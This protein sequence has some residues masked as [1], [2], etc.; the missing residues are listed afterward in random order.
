MKGRRIQITLHL[1]CTILEGI[2]D[3]AVAELINFD[4]S[5]SFDSVRHLYLSYGKPD[6]NLI[7]LVDQP[8]VSLR[9]CY[10]IGKEKATERLRCHGRFDIVSA[11]AL[12]SHFGV[13]APLSPVEAQGVI[14]GIALPGDDHVLI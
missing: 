2:N 6:S 9:Q 14:R 1:I 4:P 10:G 13:G 7:L 8:P 11:I 12:T 5:K 3:H